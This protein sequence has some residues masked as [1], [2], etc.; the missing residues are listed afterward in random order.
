MIREEDV[1]KIGALTRVHG[2]KGE[3][4]F[5]FT[6]DVWDRADADYLVLK[7]DGIL[8]PFF[9]EE[10]RFRSDSVA[11]VKFVDL[12]H[13]DDVQEYVGCEVFFPHELTPEDAPDEL[14]WASFTGY[15]VY[16]EGKTEQ[17]GV[18][19]QVDDSTANVLFYIETERGECIV[20]A[21][22][23]FI[24]DVDHQGRTLI[25]SLP[26]GLLDLNE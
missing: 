22:E 9:L 14:R 15:R 7:V 8:V 18:V 26:E 10:Y 6:D 24:V 21:V 13:V 1:Y 25:L 4:S 3:V 20:P 16:L 17:V 23:E 12:D 11:L 19:N 2:L 5:S